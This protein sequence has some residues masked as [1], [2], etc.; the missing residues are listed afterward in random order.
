MIPKDFMTLFDRLSR[1]HSCVEVFKDFLDVFLFVLSC[2]K[3]REDYVRIDKLY[4]EQ[5]K[6]TFM[7]MVQVVADHSE[8][9]C[10]ILGEVFMEYISHGHNGQ[11][12]TPQHVSDL[13]AGVTCAGIRP[14][15]SV[16]DPTCGSGRMLLS[17]VKSLSLTHPN[18]RIFCY[19]S[20]IDLTCVKMATINMLMN[21]IPGEIAWMNTLT[22][23][24]W[25]SFR[26]GLTRVGNVWLP[27]LLVL[28]AGDTDLVRHVEKTVKRS[29]YTTGTQLQFSFDF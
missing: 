8:G 20:D 18:G 17:A 21:S 25:K 23:E 22:L 16:Y 3:Y 6:R 2:G 14:G 9:F 13:M 26:T 4:D 1:V 19:G 5:E 7:Q 28:G 27:T 15:Q 24:H 10:D 29:G 11:F 12:F